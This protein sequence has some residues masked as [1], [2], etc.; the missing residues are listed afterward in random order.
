MFT[1][2]TLE[3]D[4]GVLLM[5]HPPFEEREKQSMYVLLQPVAT[6]LSIVHPEPSS[7][8]WSFKQLQVEISKEQ[9]PLAGSQS[10]FL[11]VKG[12]FGIGFAQPTA[13]LVRPSLST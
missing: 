7:H 9:R 13:D 5:V 4:I 1:P 12:S 6:H 8:C 10:Y 2:V 11:Q 3:L